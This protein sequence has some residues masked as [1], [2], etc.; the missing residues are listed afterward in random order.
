MPHATVP[1]YSFTRNHDLSVI[2]LCFFK[3]L[4][5]ITHHTSCSMWFTTHDDPS[6]ETQN[7]AFNIIIIF[8][9]ENINFI[10]VRRVRVVTKFC[11]VCTWYSSNMFITS[12]CVCTGMCVCVCVCVYRTTWYTTLF[13]SL[14]CDLACCSSFSLFDES[15]G[16]SLGTDFR[17]KVSSRNN[18]YPTD[19]S[20]HR[21]QNT[22]SFII[23]F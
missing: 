17:G 3:T 11:H 10:T 8:T 23:Q 16:S 15:C 14:A 7:T 20:H 12:W 2:N 1:L 18:L 13:L 22:S 21:S 4:L 19:L 9:R 5:F 6:H